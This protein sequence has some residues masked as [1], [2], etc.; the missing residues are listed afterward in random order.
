MMNGPAFTAQAFEVLAGPESIT[1]L[2]RDGS[3]RLARV[4]VDL[5]DVDTRDRQLVPTTGAARLEHP[6]T[7]LGL[8]PLAEPVHTRTATNFWLISAFC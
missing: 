5:F 6:A 2:H 1:L 4:P 3:V 8:H 7:V